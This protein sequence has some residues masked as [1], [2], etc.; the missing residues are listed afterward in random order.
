MADQQMSISEVLNS[1]IEAADGE[2]LSVDDVMNAFG[3]RSYGP[4][5]FLIGALSFSPL[6]GIPGASILFGSLVIILMA[7]YILRDSAPWVPGW[8]LRQD[9]ESG[10]ACEAVDKAKPYLERMERVVRPRLE[11]FTKAPW[12]YVVAILII[13]MGVTMFPLA[14]VPWGVMAPSLVIALFGL[15]MMTSDGLLI[16]IGLGGSIASLA[17]TAWLLPIGLIF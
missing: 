7:Q 13:V 9:A 12:T 15:G 17:V 16:A 5:L 4:L 3:R 8:I 10:R 6:G 11:P 1:V 14:L 2:R